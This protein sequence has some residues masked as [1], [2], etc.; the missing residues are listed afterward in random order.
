MKRGGIL[1][2]ESAQICIIL[3]YTFALDTSSGI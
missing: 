1:E 3:G 2:D